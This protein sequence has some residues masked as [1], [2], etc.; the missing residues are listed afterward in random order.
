M[1]LPQ[2]SIIIELAIA[3]AEELGALGAAIIAA[4]GAGLYPDLETAVASMTRIRARIEP[5]A[6]LAE[7][8]AR[9]SVGF[10]ALRN[11]LNPLWTTL[12]IP[13]S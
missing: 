5:D 13:S 10:K 7:I 3:E 4:V 1:K 9:R 11:A 2:V 12:G 8:L 6:A